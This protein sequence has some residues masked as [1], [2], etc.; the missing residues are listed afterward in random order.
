MA[1]VVQWRVDIS[2]V[3]LL[4]AMPLAA[5]IG[6]RRWQGAAVLGLISLAWVS[7]LDK[8]FEGPVLWHV[9]HGHGVVLADLVGLAGLVG[10]GVLTLRLVLRS[11]VRRDDRESARSAPR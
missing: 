4:L 9:S 1:E 3:C 2:L 6:W 5:W 10:A 7:S 8:Q 11:A